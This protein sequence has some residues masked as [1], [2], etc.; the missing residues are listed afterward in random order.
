MR[1]A[2]VRAGVASIVMGATLLS[3]ALAV[4]SGSPFPNRTELPS[5]S[6]PEPQ[7][8]SN[9]P[10]FSI[11]GLVESPDRYEWSP[12]MTVGQAVAAAGGYARG[13]SRDELQIQHLVDGRLVSRAVTEDDP[14]Q[15]DD[16]I[17]V[18]GKAVERPR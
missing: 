4:A 8:E 5:G 12:G 2:R 15:P 16:V 9:S 1:S 14:V 13:G 3:G 7:P 6:A 11:F 17:I 10:T 18:R